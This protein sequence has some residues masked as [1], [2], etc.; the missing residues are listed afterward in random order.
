[1]FR[2]VK[3]LLISVLLLTLVLVGCGSA[4]KPAGQ[5]ATQPNAQSTVQ[6]A[7]SGGELD[8][9]WDDPPTLD[10]QLASDVSAG[11]IVEEVFSG[12]VTLDRNLKVVPDLATGWTVSPDKMTYTFSI[13]PAATF[14]DGKPV[15]AQDFKYS[16]E[17]AAD[18]KL[19][20][21]TVDTYLGDIVGVKEKLSGKS[22]DVSGVKVI[23]AHTLQITITSP[24]AT[25]LFLAKLTY[26][27]AFVLDQ[28]NVESGPDWTHH[29]NGTGPFMLKD[30]VP[31]DH[32]TLVRNPRYLHGPPHLDTVKFLLSGGNGMVMYQ[33]NEIQVTGVGLSDLPLVTENNSA[34]SKEVHKAPPSFD[35]SYIGFNV[36][37][38]PFDDVKVRQALAMAMDKPEIASKVLDNQVIPA[39]GIL[40]PGFPAYN[41]NLKGLTYNVDE[42][43]KLLSE[44]K[45]GSD[46]SK[47][48]HITLTVPGQLGSSISPDLEAILAMWKTNL[49]I[50]VDVQQVEWATFLSDLNAYRLQMYALD[51]V[52]DYPDPQDF[53][54]IL[55]YS[56]SQN[57]QTR[58]SN[59]QVDSL[60]E[61]ART[62]QDQTTRY[63]LYQQA[64]QIIVND[65]PWIP[66][67][68]SGQGDVLIKPQVKD[69]LLLPIVIE[70]YRYIYIQK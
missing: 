46:P 7:P 44:S 6:S 13:N 30:Y 29:P 45:Y 3:L 27:T 21:T 14:Q 68:Y 25:D 50:Q 15:T 10:P 47:I 40:P 37:M 59:P 65:A 48:P 43:K 66:L 64:E 38:P 4:A 63:S 35:T 28:K 34:L 39:Y 5:P 58:Y 1:M 12:L 24:L 19:Q 22:N 53:L 52:A 8:Q 67:W 55:F 20:S 70:R 11:T 16:F 33:N 49:G 61:Q 9:L 42:A 36:T 54:D 62:E 56:H 17:R 41:P 2:K 57:N 31:G 60:L 18:P 32:I 69:Y 51:W 26:P 23:N